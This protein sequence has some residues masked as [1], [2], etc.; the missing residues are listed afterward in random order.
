MIKTILPHI[1]GV[2]GHA[3]VMDIVELGE[4]K[5]YR[6]HIMVVPHKPGINAPDIPVDLMMKARHFGYRFEKMYYVDTNHLCY[7]R[8]TR[9][10]V[11]LTKK[12]ENMLML[13]MLLSMEDE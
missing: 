2:S 11:F 8:G 13:E 12:S 5:G 9:T 6:A 3:S 10:L 1:F 7:Y 4:Q